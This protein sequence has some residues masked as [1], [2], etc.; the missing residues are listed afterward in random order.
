MNVKYRSNSFFLCKFFANSNLIG[1]DNDGNDNWAISWE[2]DTCASYRLTAT[3]EDDE[4]AMI[5]S[6]PIV[7]TFVDCPQQR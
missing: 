5:I 6:L 1:V 3:A 2:P 4:G 7:I